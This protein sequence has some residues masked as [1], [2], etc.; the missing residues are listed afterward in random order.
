M[1][2][3]LFPLPTPPL[4]FSF[5]F[6][7]YFSSIVITSIIITVIVSDNEQTQWPTVIVSDNEQAEILWVFYRE[8]TICEKSKY[9]G[10]WTERLL[11]VVRHLIAIPYCVDWLFTNIVSPT[12]FFFFNLV[13]H[14]QNVSLF[15][16]LSFFP[17]LS[18]SHCFIH[19]HSHIINPTS[20]LCHSQFI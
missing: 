18:L 8:V 20:S 12:A 11:E 1:W 3:N 7:A 17:S 19:T 2:M 5:P 10:F 14:K 16:L 13:S 15:S 4:P 9:D 6:A